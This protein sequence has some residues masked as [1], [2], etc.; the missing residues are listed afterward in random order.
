MTVSTECLY[1]RASRDWTRNEP[2]LLSDYTARPFLL[3]WCEPVQ[4]LSVLDLGCGEG[5]FARNLKYRGAGSIQGMDLSSEMID[6]ARE[7]ESTEGLGIQY[8][9]GNAT[10]LTCFE[11]GAFDRVVAVFLFNYLSSEQTKAT[12]EEVIRVLKPGGRFVFAVPHPSLP[13]GRLQ[14]PPFFFSPGEAGY[15]S[16]RD[17]S[18]EGEIYR[19]DGVSVPV[20]CVH[21]T[22]SDYF[23]CLREAGF[24]SMPD[25]EELCVT[26]EML[27]ID[28]EFFG[29]LTD[30]PLHLAFR[31]E[32]SR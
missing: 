10:D 20:R 17:E 5:Y 9:A 3:D 31:V 25:L 12:M 28:P 21:K 30:E 23:R 18:F 19:R 27:E 22:L 26:P 6:R 11:D 13:F 7:A 16:G 29:P 14:K 4:S 15:F 1:D 8:R 32:K 24:A 2:L